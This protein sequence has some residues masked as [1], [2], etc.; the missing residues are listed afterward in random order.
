[1]SAADATACDTTLLATRRALGNLL[2]K[3]GRDTRLAA[4]RA[5]VALYCL[6]ACRRVSLTTGALANSVGLIAVPSDAHVYCAVIA[7]VLSGGRL[8]LQPSPQHAGLPGPAY[9]FDVQGSPTGD[10]APY[11]FDRAVY[12][13]VFPNAERTPYF[14][15]D[16]RPLSKDEVTQLRARLNTL[17]NVKE[18][19]VALVVRLGCARDQADAFGRANALPVFI[20]DPELAKDVLGVDADKWVADLAEFWRELSEFPSQPAPTAPTAPTAQ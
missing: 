10:G 6:A 4:E 12:A 16:H 5:A 3:A 19:A 15:L 2:A 17:R 8:A 14:A 9:S 13:A 7:T 1:M 18:Q 20:C 11:A